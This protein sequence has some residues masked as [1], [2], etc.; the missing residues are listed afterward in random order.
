MTK[1]DMTANLPGAERFGG[2]GFFF[3]ALG[4]RPGLREGAQADR[5]F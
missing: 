4:R 3:Q 5:T 1:Q 2:A